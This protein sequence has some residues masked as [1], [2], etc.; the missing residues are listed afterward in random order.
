MIPFLDESF[1]IAVSFGATGGPE[2]RTEIVALAGGHE[3]RNARWAE[4]R[5]RYDAG[6]GVRSLADLR[7]VA[8]LFERA[9]GRLSGF[10]FRDPFDHASTA[11]GTPPGLL[12]CALGTGDGSRTRFVL[13]KTYGWGAAA[14]GRAIALPV[15]GTLRVALDGVEQAEGAA[16]AFDAETAE[17]VFAVPPPGGAEVTAGFLFDVP[18]RFDTDR[19]EISLTHF[20]A[21][22]APSIP[23]VEIR[24]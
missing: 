17:V 5:R 8:A 12:D 4:S 3:T 21:G 24:R 6:T 18:V 15:A 11:D 7:A 22:Q 9:R 19:L 13:V 23:L 14:Y 2:R 16:F 20:A 1:P 10:R